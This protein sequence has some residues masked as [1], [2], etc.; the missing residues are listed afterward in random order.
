MKTDGVTFRD[1]GSDTR[2]GWVRLTPAYSRSVV[3]GVLAAQASVGDKVL[4]PFGGSGTTAL[5]CAERGFDCDTLDVNP[6]LCWLAW[7][8]TSV[9]TRDDVASLDGIAASVRGAILSD[10]AA[11][12]WTPPLHRIDRW[13]HPAVLGCLARA[14]QALH[15]AEVGP[16]H[17]LATVAFCR[18]L[19]ACARVSFGHQSM[20]F[21]SDGRPLRRK[22]VADR[23]DAAVTSV[24]RGATSRILRQPCVF[25][26]DAR[27]LVA[28][29][30]NCRYDRVITSPPYANRMSYVREL[31]PYLY[32]LGHLDS[33]A[34]AGALDWKAIG[35]TWGGA[36]SRL[37]RWAPPPDSVVPWPPLE[38]LCA[39]I[40]A[41]GGILGAYVCRYAH[42]MHAHVAA[43]ATRVRPGGTVHY[44]IG[45]AQFYDVLV[46]VEEML[47]ALLEAHG[48]HEARIEVLRQRS[49]NRE[50]KEFMVSARKSSSTGGDN[51]FPGGS[52]AWSFP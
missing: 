6:F 12:A 49:S 19:I 31:R 42:D 48:F 44:V 51:S 10:S 16:A 26:G 13:W 45:N 7:V 22:E 20:S 24:A 37:A 30:T 14:F 28:V 52:N 23:W 38:D 35:G 3:E 17:R 27:D 21:R 11:T 18:T 5:A 36:T 4:D 9:Y 47:R 43:V 32:W 40:R 15:A 39:Q 8:K 33:G 50:L 29:A 34:A 41:R 46:P 2:H 25:E 1:N